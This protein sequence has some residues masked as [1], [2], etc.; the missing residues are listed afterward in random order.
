MTS[1]PDALGHLSPPLHRLHGL[2]SVPA[3][4]AKVFRVV[5]GEV[6]G[7]SGKEDL[8]QDVSRVVRGLV[9]VVKVVDADLVV[10]RPHVCEF[11]LVQLLAFVDGRDLHFVRVQLLVCR[12]EEEMERISLWLFVLFLV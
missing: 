5:P 8:V 12:G 1:P 10:G 11:E 6:L 9:L 3:P 7:P 4:V 2:L